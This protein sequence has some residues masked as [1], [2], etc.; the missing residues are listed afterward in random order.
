MVRTRLAAGLAILLCAC[1]LTGCWSLARRGAARPATTPDPVPAVF[2]ASGVDT[3]PARFWTVFADPQLDALIDRALAG[4]FTLRQAQD[5]LDQSRALLAQSAAAWWPTLSL[6][7][8]STRT[9]TELTTG[10]R[11]TTTLANS[12]V[13][14]LAAAY[15]V[16][17]WGRVDAGIRAA[18][19]DAAGRDRDA[20][21]AALTVAAELAATWLALREN[22]AQQEVIA[23]QVARRDNYVTV[24]ERRTALLPA[25]RA[26]DL[27]QQ[28]QLLAAARAEQSE[29]HR[30]E[31]VLRLRLAV[32]L[33]DTPGSFVAPVPAGLPALPTLP[34]AGIPADLLRRRPDLQAAQARL[35][36]ADERVRGA[37]ADRFPAIT[38]SAAASTTA[39]HAHDL[40]DNWLANLAAG[41]AAPLIDGH[42]RAA[43]VDQRQAAAREAFNT[44]RAAILT[45][46]TEVE[47]ALVS[48]RHQQ[49]T[50]AQLDEQLRL[51]ATAVAQFDLRYRNGAADY[52]RWQDA[53]ITHS[54]LERQALAARRTLLQYRL[55]LY[56]ALA[57]DLPAAAPQGAEA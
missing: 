44:Y 46:V 53:V 2:T 38:L 41:L 47:D 12:F 1:A 11:T 51:S 6:S 50:V 4:N 48:E 40:F 33:G 54:A 3:I 24:T 45:A 37:I 55:N 28:Q 13:L 9:R 23:K 43:V 17:L 32:L 36:A 10:S 34:A 20:R 19:F 39:A 15:E 16:D 49:E 42:R 7:S 27:L 8:S 25:T 22:A 57:G 14:G 21:T 29:S 52:L 18:E 31:E 56:R 26:T 5:R 35:A 30:Q